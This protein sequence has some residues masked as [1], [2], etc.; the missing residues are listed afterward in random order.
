VFLVCVLG[1]PAAL[2]VN[3]LQRRQHPGGPILT[4][5]EAVS[6]ALNQNRVVRNSG[7]RRKHDFRVSTARSRRLPQF[8]VDALAGS[9]LQPF[10]FTFPAGSF[11]TYP[12]TGP[13]PST[14]AKVT[15]PAKFDLVTAESTSP[16]APVRS[17][18]Y[19]GH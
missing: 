11:G 17:A 8:H 6:L 19:P 15:T 12:G 9:L 16:H 4:A 13:I 10:D 14:D 18:R 7:S 5:D 1:P 3:S 2:P